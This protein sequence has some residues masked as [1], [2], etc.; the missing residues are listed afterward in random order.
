MKTLVMTLAINTELLQSKYVKNNFIFTLGP[1]EKIFN[2]R[3]VVPLGRLSYAVYLV[4]ITVMMII[5]S[6]QRAAVVPRIS[7]LVSNYFNINIFVDEIIILMMNKFNKNIKY[8][9]TFPLQTP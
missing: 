3:F 4:N 8:I 9:Y 7:N 2:N 1:I 5:E 6:E